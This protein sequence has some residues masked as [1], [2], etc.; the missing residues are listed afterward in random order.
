MFC[1]S[2]QCKTGAKKKKYFTQ[3]VSGKGMGTCGNIFGVVKKIMPVNIDNFA[4]YSTTTVRQT[5]CDWAARH[6][7]VTA[8]RMFP[9]QSQNLV[10]LPSRSSLFDLDPLIGPDLLHWAKGI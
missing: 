10:E 2:E 9:R 1:L 5:F 4:T 6:E 3:N 8:C 7:I